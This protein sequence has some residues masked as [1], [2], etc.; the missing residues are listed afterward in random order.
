MTPKWGGHVRTTSWT[1]NGADLKWEACILKAKDLLT[2]WPTWGH[3][4]HNLWPLNLAGRFIY[5]RRF[6]TQ[7]LKSLIYSCIISPFPSRPAFK[8]TSNSFFRNVLSFVNQEA[9]DQDQI[10]FIGHTKQGLHSQWFWSCCLWHVWFIWRNVL[11]HGNQHSQ[12]PKIYKNQKFRI[13]MEGDT[14]IQS[15]KAQK[16][17]K[18]TCS[19]LVEKF[20]ENK[21]KT[22]SKGDTQC[23]SNINTVAKELV[24]ENIAR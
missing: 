10:F 2:T 17:D 24:S 9:R 19:W 15:F 13:K 12:H 11:Y 7:T 14:K 6:N 20:E 16:M 8:R 4:S 1:P 18:S 22:C 5:G 23:K 3:V 21:K